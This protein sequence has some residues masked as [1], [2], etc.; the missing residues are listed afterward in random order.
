MQYSEVINLFHRVNCRF[1]NF[2]TLIDDE[3]SSS[4][5]GVVHQVEVDVSDENNGG[6]RMSFTERKVKLEFESDR[7]IPRF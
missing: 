4:Q 2:A 3:G 7:E 1:W 5:R 6:S